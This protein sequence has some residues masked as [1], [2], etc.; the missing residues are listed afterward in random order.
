MTA[1]RL[2]SAAAAIAFGLVALAPRGEAHKPITSPFTFNEDVFPIVRDRCAACHVSGGVAPMSLMTHADTV[3]WGESIRIELLSGHMP[4]WSVDSAPGRFRNV[5]MLSAREMNVLLTWAS[6]GTPSGEPEKAPGP[7]DHARDWPLGTPDLVLPIPED[8]TLGADTQER[9]AEFMLS[10][11]PGTPRLLRAVD[12]MP[13]APAMVRS[14]TIAVETGAGASPQRGTRTTE[15]TLGLWL[16]GD[17]PV[18]LDAGGAFVIPPEA[19]LTVRVRYRKT[20][21]Y[22]R[23]SLTDRSRVGL[24]FAK[25]PAGE[26][27]ALALGTEVVTTQEP[28]RAVA[29]YPDPAL[30]HLRVSVIATRPNGS[31]EELIAFRPHAGWARR[32]WFVEP[33]V[34]PAGTRIEVLPAPIGEGLLP[35]GALPV[36]A[37]ALSSVRLTL[38]VLPE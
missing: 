31:R 28:L 2:S 27:G 37:P 21:E 10:L 24:Y 16:P 23:A 13:G 12:L 3:P 35:P 14:A 30:A 22:E 25:E 5:Q 1:A 36:E 8:V 26:L 4:P 18:P 20:W 34:L 17:H 32:Y 6:G 38:N 29:I 33:V 15:R 9:V 19:R 11:P 7:I